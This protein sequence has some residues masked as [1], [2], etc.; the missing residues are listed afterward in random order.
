MKKTVLFI[1]T[2]LTFF[3][4][5]CKVVEQE[6]VIEPTDYMFTETIGDKIPINSL[7]IPYSTTKG[8][9]SNFINIYK[10]K[11]INPIY[12][13]DSTL[14]SHQMIFNFDQSYP[15]DSIS[16]FNPIIDGYDSLNNITIYYSLNGYKYNLLYQDLI[17]TTND[18]I[19]NLGDQIVKSIKITFKDS[20]KAQSI[21]D[22]SF[23]LGN[24]Y[25]VKEE[26]ELSNAFL[27]YSGWTGADGIFTFD[28]NN[29]GDDIG[30]EHL[31]TGFI[32]SDTF[33][34]EV[35]ENN[36]LRKSYNFINNSF[37]YLTSD[38]SF[39]RNQLSFDYDMSSG[40]PESVLKPDLY[41]GSVARNLFDN[42]GLS[43][44]NNEE[45]TL[46][47]INEGTMWL[48]N[49]VNSS[50]SMDLKSVQ[51]ISSLV[52]WNY[53]ANVNYGVKTFTLYQS[54]DGQ[55]FTEISSYNMNP[56]SGNQEEPYTLKIQFDQIETQFLKLEINESYDSS[57]VGLG[58]ILI[59]DNNQHTIYPTVTATSE[60]SETTL[61]ETTS[62]LWLQD[63]VI[64]DNKLYVFPILVKDYEDYFK[65]HNVSMVEVPIENER[66]NYQ[67]AT[68][69]SS[70]LM[71]H[72]ID[73]GIIYYGAGIMDN[74]KSD[75][76]IYIYGYKDLN[77]RSLVV[78]R[79][80]PQDITDF[81]KWTYF[82][83]QTWDEDINQSAP[84]IDRVSAEL[85]VTYLEE[86]PYA[87]KYML[88]VMENTTS[89]TISYS[90]SDS[91]FGPFSEYTQVYQ[92]SEAEYLPGSFTYNAKMHPNLSTYDNIVISYNVNSLSVG[93]LNDARY[94]YPR[95]ISLSPV[96][97]KN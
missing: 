71:V 14:K 56:A 86:G 38:G 9:L 40:T 43:I 70:P 36:K 88:V 66:F 5:S 76:Y 87:N 60:N 2:L 15:I 31:T 34:G 90:I 32:F 28:I 54:I 19:I 83:G 26:K 53:N 16:I 97:E 72:T 48:T 92:T 8:N 89:G 30:V 67:N 64:I 3:M 63:G 45:A 35:Y 4:Y 77:S 6:I 55:A 50:I 93:H 96:K 78:G 62:R 25:I 22:V 39:D 41:I 65:V 69:Y 91:P 27:R 20:E 84:L 51:N 1:L 47:N 18:N 74:S 95:F 10:P 46:T 75:G 13:M 57:H 37:G 80:L 68:Y 17:L 73:G 52:I 7:D 21:G 61:N 79:F 44:S 58:K 82:N 12:F 23:Y 29:G 24:G 49:N 81:N 33:I 42:D 94:Y 59:K 85:S 11:T